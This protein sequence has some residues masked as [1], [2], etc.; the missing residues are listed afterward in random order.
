MPRPPRKMHPHELARALT[1]IIA[2]ITDCGTSWAEHPGV[3]SRGELAE[4]AERTLHLLM[5][6]GAKAESWTEEPGQKKFARRRQRH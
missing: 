2:H 1:E 6:L 5:W 3:L 4:I